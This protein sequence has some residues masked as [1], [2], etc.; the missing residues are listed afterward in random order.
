MNLLVR[1]AFQYGRHYLLLIVALSFMVGVTLSA[2]AEMLS[3]GVITN[4]GADFFSLFSSKEEEGSDS[5]SL[6]QV[7]ERWSEI[8]GETGA[9]T[10]R[11]ASTYLSTLKS[12]NPLNNLMRWFAG[13]VD[14]LSNLALLALVLIFVA[15][16]RGICVFGASYTQQ[17]VMI[18]VSRDLR[19]HYFQH[20]QSLPMRFYHKHNIGSLSCRAYEDAYQIAEAIQA[21]MVTYIQTPFAVLSSLL[22]CL[23]MSFELS[24]VV[25]VAFPILILPIV[26]F[27]KR[28]KR[29][30]RR[31]LKNHEGIWSLLH[32]F[33]AGIQTIKIFGMERFSLGRYSKQNGEMAVLEEKAARYGYMARPVLHAASTALL[34][35]II[36]YGLYVARLSVSEILVFC[37]MV[38][39]MYEPIK[40]FNDENIKIQ[41]GMAAAER[42]FEVLDLKTAD[43]DQDGAL[44]LPGLSQEIEFDRVSFRYGDEWVLQDV[45][46]SIR[47]GEAVA[48]IGPT[49]A[50]KSTL[51]QLLPRLYEVTEG[52][53][54]IDGKSLSTYQL[55]T[56]R[57]QISY[58]PQKP[59]LFIDSIGENIAVGRPVTLAQIERAAKRAHADE[60]IQKLPQGY[61][62]A[63]TA[64]MGGSLSGGQQQ[65]LAIARAL[66]QEASI[67]IMDEATSALD[68][69]SEDRIKQAVRELK[70]EVT[71]IIIAHRLST[72]EYVDRIVYLE[73][74]KLVAQGTKDELL[75]TCPGFRMMWEMGQLKG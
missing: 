42:M 52:E 9:I 48:L 31:L 8:A 46:F 56:L 44:P 74:G 47:K 53:I 17:L 60:F 32:Q 51:A 35:A 24:L 21:G 15:I 22:I 67:L 50:G 7:E 18:R 23:Y 30:Q 39:V 27:S 4:A 45:S 34:A 40:R 5:I 33:L 13:R 65:R 1:T 29:I 49:G 38:Y 55:R 54:R 25:F 26:Y 72:I 2:Q 62:T 57:Q 20:I 69:V 70:G 64:D 12:R 75:A 28:V 6:S 58:V 68:T 41:R 61:S 11:D 73:G 63:L 19:Q 43:Q 10:K 37:G 36:L 16:F 14:W 59:F 71:Q 3:F 66:V